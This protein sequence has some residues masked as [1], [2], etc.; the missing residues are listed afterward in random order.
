MVQNVPIR[1]GRD[2][3]ELFRQRERLLREIHIVLIGHF[4]ALFKHVVLL[5]QTL[6]G[7][8]MGGEIKVHE[9]DQLLGG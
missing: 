3:R 9:G 1:Y 7:G 4:T 5:P 6:H 2:L 8:S